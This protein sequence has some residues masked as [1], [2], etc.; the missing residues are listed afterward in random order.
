MNKKLFLIVLITGIA[1]AGAPGLQAQVK[2]G[3][4]LSGEYLKGESGSPYA[5]GS[6]QNSEALGQAGDDLLYQFSFLHFAAMFRAWIPNQSAEGE[7]TD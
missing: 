3:G 1:A 7:P 2:Y 6:F 4:Y 5:G